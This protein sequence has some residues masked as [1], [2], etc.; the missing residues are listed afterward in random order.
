MPKTDVNKELIVHLV[1]KACK[2]S[3]LLR[4]LQSTRVELENFVRTAAH[5]LKTPLSSLHG[6]LFLLQM[7]I[8][9]EDKEEMVSAMQEIEQAGEDMANLIDA[10]LEYTRVG[11]Q[12]NPSDVD[13]N[14]VM[15]IIQKRL[16]FHISEL[17]GND[18]NRPPAHP[19]GKRGS[20]FTLPAPT[21]PHFQRDQVPGRGTT[22]H[23]IEV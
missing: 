7:A 19:S 11:W 6:H 3:D 5:D 8:D 20:R 18:P 14:P 2:H 15:E 4:E 21:K 13:L 17:G 12:F 16:D 9:S 1:R 22:G 23:P 10:L